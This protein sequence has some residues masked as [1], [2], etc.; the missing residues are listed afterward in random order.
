[1]I[2]D[3]G[4]RTDAGDNDVSMYVQSNKYELSF[5]TGIRQPFDYIRMYRFAAKV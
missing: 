1:M 3:L 2:V 4:H 5:S